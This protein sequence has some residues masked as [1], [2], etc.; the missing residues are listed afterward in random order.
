MREIKFR[1]WHKEV[2]RILF[3]KKQSHVFSWEEEGQPVILMQYTGLKDK[4]GVEIFEGDI[5]EEKHETR[6]Y[7]FTIEWD[8]YDCCFYPKP[9][10]FKT[11]LVKRMSS[12][13]TEFEVIGNI[14]SNPE[15]TK[16]T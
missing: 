5:V 3:S 9:L 16:K 15:L 13:Y 4:N 10:N 2:K 11:E 1:A 7:N 8:K 6:K 12:N 14:Y